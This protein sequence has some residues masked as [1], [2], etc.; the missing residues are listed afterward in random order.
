MKDLERYKMKILLTTL[1]SKY[2]HSNLALKYLY[3]VASKGEMDVELQ[4]FTINNDKDYPYIE[5]LRGGFDIVCF[6]CYIWNIEEII[7]LGSNIKKAAP[8]TKILLGGPEVSYEYMELMGKN[9][10]IDFI[11]KGEG[12]YPFFEFCREIVLEKYDFSKVSSLVYRDEGGIKDNPFGPLPLMDK[13]PFPYS[14]LDLED[15]KVI[16]YESSRGCPYRCAY[17]LSSLEKEIRAHS[18]E[19]TRRDIGY[20]LYKQVKQV[21]FLDRTFNY[22]RGRANHI[23]Q[24]IIDNDNGVTNFHFEICADLLDSD[25][26]SVIQRAR[27]GLFQ[28]E[29]GIQ[30]TNPYALRAVNRKETISGI[31]DNVKKLLEL[32][33]CHIHVDLIAG[34]PF[35]DYK[36]F[37]QSFDTVYE[38]KADNLQLGFLKLLKGTPLRMNK[39]VHEYKFRDYAPYEIIS[40]K[41]LSPVDVIKLKMIETVLEL[42][43]NRGGFDKTLELLVKETGITAF[44]FYE[45]LADF[46]YSGGYQH[47]SH[48]KEDLYRILLRFAESREKKH[49]GIV[50]RTAAVLADDLE[51]NM[52]PDAVKKFHKKGWEI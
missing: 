4:E 16:Y 34:L 43:S 46:Y 2:I 17:C 35:E 25:G 48:K 20:F 15:D 13:I 27:K 6:S 3:T 37:G 28:F 10:W 39:E 1:N 23:W 33:N 14:I 47:R 42:Y 7:E 52:N 9:P 22:D 24:Y 45:Q 12:E 40:N 18:L 49:K 36:S 41:Y 21:K 51:T 32:E 30:S 5:I 38:L 8:N 50:E 44:N 11:I 31:T 29:I 26:L 19:R